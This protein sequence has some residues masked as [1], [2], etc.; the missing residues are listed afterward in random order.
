MILCLPAFFEI[1]EVASMQHSFVRRRKLDDS[2]MNGFVIFLCEELCSHDVLNR[3]QFR[4][5]V[6]FLTLVAFASNFLVLRSM[7]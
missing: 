4:P 1:A 2:V 7:K 5:T 3:A 6:I